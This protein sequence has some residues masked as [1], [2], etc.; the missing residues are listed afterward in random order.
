MSTASDVQAVPT[1]TMDGQPVV[2]DAG[3][4]PV[5]DPARPSETVLEAPAASAAQVD[6]AVRGAAR[7]ARGWAETPLAERQQLVAAAARA[8]TE[9][10]AR[11]PLARLLTSENGKVLAES[12]FEL[13]AVGAVVETFCG[14]A[15]S[16]LSPHRWPDGGEV[17][18]EPVGVVA[19]LLPF[20]WPVS[21]LA[22]KVAPALLCG[23]TVVAK[24]PPTCP[25][26]A[27]VVAQAMAAALPAGVLTTV[28][29]PGVEVGEALV[30]HP[31]VAMVSLTGGTGTGRAVMK[32]ASPRLLPVLLELGGNDAAIVGPDVEPDEALADA[33]LQAAFLTSGQV[34]MA[35]KRL[36]V[37]AHRL[38]VFVDALVARAL[39]RR[40]P[41]MASPRTPRSGRCTPRGQ[42]WSPR[43]WSQKQRQGA[44]GSTARDACVRPTSKRAAT[45]CR[46]RSS[47]HPLGA[48][49]SSPMSSSP[50][51]P[52]A[53]IRRSRRCRRRRQRLA[54]R[55]QRIRVEQRRGARPEVAHRLQVGTVFHNAHGPG[56]LDP[57]MPFGGWKESGIGCEYG[58][59][60]MTVYTRQRSAAPSAPLTGSRDAMV[61]VEIDREKCMGS[62]NCAYWA[63]AVFDLDDDGF[64]IV[65]GDP[66]ADEERVRL[67]AQS[68]PT[69]AITVGEGSA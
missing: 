37:P 50:P 41:V 19:A 43:R 55:A 20:N 39:R 1:L 21:V 4:Y 56:A 67:A 35:L 22:S 42:P 17:H 62:G 36:Y 65:V 8:A 60:G 24:P 13:A 69:A 2:G 63:P 48:T 28:N 61:E 3:T 11:S 66:A 68:C 18:R 25:G 58:T 51:A 44:P 23:N 6:M 30:D 16:A 33:L 31:D 59:E 27:L 53:P 45:S 54:L 34:C 7:A 15:D 14:L 46:R 57:R 29:G 5:H 47:R 9:A 26:A 32:A 10:A 64:A 49:A 12:Q 40:S 52:G 38:G